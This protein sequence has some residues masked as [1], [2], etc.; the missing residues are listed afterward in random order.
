MGQCQGASWDCRGRHSE[1]KQAGCERPRDVGPG[2]H[3]KHR[4]NPCEPSSS[5]LGFPAGP[6][7]WRSDQAGKLVTILAGFC[8]RRAAHTAS[9]LHEACVPLLLLPL[10]IQACPA[11]L[12]PI[13]NNGSE[14]IFGQVFFLRE[15]FAKASCSFMED[16]D[17]EEGEKITIK[18]SLKR[19]FKIFLLRIKMKLY[20]IM[21]SS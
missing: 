21:E 15:E 13:E 5:N 12:L 17:Y 6:S 1:E 18:Y 14:I 2:N 11:Y 9:A 8:N 10:P 7:S 3:G 4:V 16:G 19:K 20:E